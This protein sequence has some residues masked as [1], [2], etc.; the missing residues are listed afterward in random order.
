[1]P[2][3]TRPAAKRRFPHGLAPPS[4]L[5]ALSCEYI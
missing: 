2:A 1:V 4:S 5:D 3:A